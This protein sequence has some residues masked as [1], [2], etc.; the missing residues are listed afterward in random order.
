MEIKFS[1]NKN[2]NCVVDKSINEL[3][4][5]LKKLS[6]DDDMLLLS[7]LAQ[8]TFILNNKIRKRGLSASEIHFSR[9]AYD[10]SNLHIQNRVLC[11]I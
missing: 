4:T 10:H 1:P 6:P 8:A 9:D 2:S 11:K 3:E 7:D 5:E